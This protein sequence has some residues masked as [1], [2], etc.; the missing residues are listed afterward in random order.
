MKLKFT[1]LAA[2]CMLAAI[3]S[4]GQKKVYFPLSPKPWLLRGNS[5][6]H[7]SINFIGTR[8]AQPLVFKVNNQKAGYLDYDP[9]GT[10]NTTFGYEGL[11]SNI[12]SDTTGAGISAFGYRA[13]YSNTTGS[14]NTAHGSGALYFN[15]TGGINTAVGMEAL[16]SNTEGGFNT[17]TG[18]FSLYANTI[19]EFNTSNGD[20]SLTAN[21]TGSFNTAAGT[22]FTLSANTEGSNNTANGSLAMFS[23]T[24][25]N[26]N[27]ALGFQALSVNATGNNNTAIGFG[28]DVTGPD[29]SNATAIGYGALA[30]ASDKVRIG[31]TD[32]NSIGGQV[33]W[34]SFSDERIKKDIKEN[35]P[36]LE[37]IKGLKP[38][39]YHFSVAKEN[40]LLGVQA[41]SEKYIGSLRSNP[42]KASNKGFRVPDIEKNMFREKGIVS[43]ANKDLEKI[44]FTGF[45]AQDVEKAAK[46]IGY[47][48]SGIDKSGKIMGLR[49]SEFVVP[50]VKAV[51][52]LASQNE[53]LQ[54]Q[55]M[56]LKELLSTSS[57]SAVTLSEAA[58]RQNVPNPF[59]GKTVIDYTLPQKYT[60]AQILVTDKAGKML[61]EVTISGNG[62]GTVS[63]D[64]AALQAG[65]YNYS[66]IVDG[67]LIETKNMML[68]K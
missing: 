58:I 12:A 68:A 21:T 40:E 45:L 24:T 46:N 22:P 31:N 33:G 19:G 30:D 55:I 28:A 16:F 64:A 50:L 65:A 25:G 66:L 15:T 54:K 41:I 2:C 39:T 17:A 44:Q 38:V 61:K 60:K 43:K 48:F 27:T 63:I 49:Y 52:E 67:H 18:A 4:V 8:D 7:P 47:D 56:V 1:L 57:K 62:N 20:Y 34:T 9:L 51:Q 35:V 26:A 53:D 14:G 6:T 59:N 13:L 23:N 36:G 32:V 11:L 37:F 42:A 3:T 10:K 29:F 5:G